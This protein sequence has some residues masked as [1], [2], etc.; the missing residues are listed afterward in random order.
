MRNAY[1]ILVGILERK[2][3]LGR[4]RCKWEDNIRM[5]LREIGR[6]LLDLSHVAY[7]KF[8]WRV[9]VNRVK[10]PSDSIQGWLS[11]CWFLK[12][13]TALWS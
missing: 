6:G 8:Q 11:D 4:P 9:L 1:K 12:K 5:D 10:E 7:N 2:L 13:F 3:Q